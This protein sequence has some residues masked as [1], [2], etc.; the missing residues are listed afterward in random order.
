[1]PNDKNHK[2]ILSSYYYADAT[3]RALA[4]ENHYKDLANEEG[5]GDLVKVFEYI[6]LEA[7]L[8][9]R[10]QTLYKREFE[11][12]LIAIIKKYGESLDNK[13][14]DSLRDFLIVNGVISVQMMP[15][16]LTRYNFALLYKYYL[17]LTTKRRSERK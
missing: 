4:V 6:R 12:L 14:T 17:G 11:N 8:Q 2:P 1:L 7:P 9:L 10:M 13:T 5:N 3:S 16:G 15:G